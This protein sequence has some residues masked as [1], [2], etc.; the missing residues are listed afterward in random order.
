MVFGRTTFI[1]VDRHSRID[2]GV[3]LRWRKLTTEIP[4][5]PKPAERGFCKRLCKKA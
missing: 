2:D 4:A 3:C 1:R 5:L